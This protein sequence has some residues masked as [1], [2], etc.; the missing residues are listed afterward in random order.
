MQKKYAYIALKTE[1][2]GSLLV[3]FVVQILPFIDWTHSAMRDRECG[4]SYG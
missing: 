4:S 2:Y 1:Y 3:Y